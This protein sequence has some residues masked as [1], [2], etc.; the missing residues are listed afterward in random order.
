M[1]HVRPNI[2]VLN[3]EQVARVHA[4][5]LEILATTGVRVNSARARRIL[6]QVTGSSA[7]GERVR[8][9]PDLVAW[10]LKVAPATVDIYDRRGKLAFTLGGQ[11]A[12]T[13][14]GVGVTNL[15]YQEPQTDR[16]TPFTREHMA[17]ST[18]LGH[19]LS[20]FDVISTIGIPQDVPP[21]LSDLVATLE[22]VANTTRPLVLLISDEAAFPTVLDL[23]ETL[24]FSPSTSSGRGS[25][26]SSGEASGPGGLA[27]RPFVVPYFN[28]ITPL[29]INTGTSDKMF[30]AI[31]RGLPIIY[32]NY[33]MAGAT[34]PITPGGTLALLNAELLAG[35]ALGQLIR[36]GTPMILGN[37][38]ATFDMK[39]MVSY[40]GP[41][42]M[43]L[44]L[45]C[46][47]M[48]AYYGLPHAGTSGSGSGWGPDVLAAG[49]LW[50]NHLTSC[51]GKV[52]LAP[53]V[54]NNL[55]SMA[56]SPTT[57]VYADE[58]I[59]HARRFA[60]GFSL[61]PAAV[62]TDEIDLVGPGGSFLTADLTLRHY[63]ATYLDSPIFPRF[64]LDA[65]QARGSSAAVDLLR[66]HTARLLAEM[67]P[68]DDH[69]ELIDRGEAFIRGALTTAPRSAASD[70]A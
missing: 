23:L 20:S 42:T 36:E 22:M 45:A 50:F 48:M 6:A 13:Y 5:S 43:L 34:T 17:L 54:G 37:L 3:D 11:K 56:F 28:P 26:A 18:R 62:A 59:R 12:E 32:S 25:S 40:Y 63:R 27:S 57:A 7:D 51:I 38:P 33:G 52:G 53:F 68:P 61:D 35:L 8:I 69:D 44:N 21:K 41:E 10:A 70:C 14:F 66:Q 47:E 67:R 24:V 1:S 64:S 58:V 65:W 49:M 55:D 16:V 46:A 19:A 30:A 4:Y 31:E 60:R 2:T 29:V 15:Y 39:T 9:P